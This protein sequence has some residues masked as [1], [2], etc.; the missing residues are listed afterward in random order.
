MAATARCHRFAVAIFVEM[1]T[2]HRLHSCDIIT[3]FIPI[4]RLFWLVLHNFFFHLWHLKH[5]HCHFAFVFL[6][7]SFRYHLIINDYFSEIEN[8]PLYNIVLIFLALRLW[9]PNNFFCL[10][11]REK[12][13]DHYTHYWKQTLWFRCVGDVKS[14]IES[15]YIRT[16]WDSNANW[17]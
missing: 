4:F 16:A 7:V 15:T 11:E 1:N 9:K 8:S 13:R 12:A 2:V 14:G 3:N 5:Q 6:K 10:E 17:L